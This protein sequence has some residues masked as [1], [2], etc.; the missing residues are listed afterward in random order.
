MP[1]KDLVKG[2]H[3]AVVALENNDLEGALKIFLSVEEPHSKIWFNIGCVYLLRGDLPEAVQAFHKTVSKDSCLAVGF[4]QRGVAHLQLEL[5]EEALSDCRRALTHLRNNTYIDYSQ[6]GLKHMLYAWEVLYN[7]AVVQCALGQWQAAQ[8]CLQEALQQQPGG[9]CPTLE[10]ALLKVQEHLSLEPIQVP[11]GKFFRPRKQEVEQLNSKMVLGTPK[12]ISSVIPNDEY[13]G[14]EPLRPQRPGFYEPCTDTTTQ[15]R[16]AGYHR[17]LV[18]Y[19][20][21]DSREVA[22]KANSL[23]YVLNKEN[24]K[25]TVIHDGQKILL[26]FSLLEPV[27]DPKAENRNLRNGIPLPPMKQP[28]TRPNVRPA[29]D[30]HVP[31]QTEGPPKDATTT[32]PA[33]SSTINSEKPF[34]VLAHREAAPYRG[35]PK[36]ETSVALQSSAYHDMPAYSSRVPR[37]ETSLAL[38]STPSDDA[39]PSGQGEP[40]KSVHVTFHSS[41]GEACAPVKGAKMLQEGA[42][43][44]AGSLLSLNVHCSYTVS[45]QVSPGTS[46][47]DLQLLL[48][49][50]IRYQAEA[51]SLHLSYRDADSQELTPVSGDE[52]LD[53]LWDQ[54]VDGRATLWCKGT[55]TCAGRS[56][57]YQMVALYPYPAEGPED[58]QFEKGDMLDIVSEVN[59]DWLEGHCRGKIGI[60]PKCFATQAAS[61]KSLT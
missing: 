55:N 2:W 5:Y 32:T 45:L 59:D 8:E 19:Y 58:L 14:F 10:D 13:I 29:V 33:Q 9:R 28:P 36:K 18:H 61:D 26:P 44:E 23:V 17:V 12:V 4:F 24:G 51:A 7:T 49:E 31:P 34:K 11:Q 37:V 30:E 50:K 43:Q 41:D 38:Q 48:Q 16:D 27:N 6:L 57:L 42:L 1:Y 56:V 40:K 39:E 47:P 15:S 25:A 52:D 53:K 54:A 20:P 46:L 3:E 35:E 21:P 22:V 60:F